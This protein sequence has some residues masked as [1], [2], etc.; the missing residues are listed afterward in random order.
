MRAVFH[1]LIALFTTFT[2]SGFLCGATLTGLVVDAS[3]MDPVAAR[4]YVHDSSGNYCLVKS[5]SGT[6]IPYEK[7]RTDQCFEIH[8]TVSAHPF[9]VEL[10]ADKYT[11]TVEHGKEYFT[12]THEV[13]VPTNEDVSV[14]IPL[15]RWTNMA[16]KGWYSGETH[17]HREVDELPTLQIA[18][19]LNVAFPLTA[20][21]TDSLHTPATNNRS[22]RQ[23]PPAKLV[24]ID[25]AHVYWPINTEYELFSVRGNRHTLGAVFVLNHQDQLELS[26]PPVGPIA[27]EARRQGG[28]LELDKHNWPW[29]MMLIPQM[30]VELYELTNN[31]IWRTEFLY[32][33]WYPE[34]AAPYMNI[35]MGNG[36]FTERGWVNFGFENYYALLNSGFKL[37]PTGGTASGV[38]PVP[39]GYGR[40]YVKI[41]GDFSYEKWIDGLLAGHSFVT[42]GPMLTT[43]A[44]R[45]T[46][47][48]VKV[49]GKLESATK[50]LG[51]EI[52]VNGRVAK[53]VPLAT[54][55]NDNGS[56][57]MAI[58]TTLD[59]KGSCWIAVRAFCRHSDNRFNFAHTAPV[60]FDVPERP[61]RPSRQQRDYLAG[62]VRD[63]IERSRSMLTEDQLRE[64][65]S[66]LKTYE[67]LATSD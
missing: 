9:H 2:S 39:F 51:V 12:A 46:N 32:G 55:Q 63:E 40:V 62:R 65:E 38:H 49:A 45:I 33:D 58:D 30:D 1:L 61:L 47:D 59:L 16:A 18:E 42:T 52:I 64:F 14:V 60:Y 66:A 43:S 25:K 20:W 10:H 3:S 57:Q 19:D 31:H 56:Y 17:V 67:S 26:A 13:T 54:L 41:D 21:V 11:I 48:R 35:E 29:S 15:K 5:K 24:Q 36:R 7:E 23:I 53:S 50:P 22:T 34:Y 27:R 8:T 44:R 37:Q 28:F 4:V 6:A